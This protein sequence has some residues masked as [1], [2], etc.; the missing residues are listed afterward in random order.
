M[1][2]FVF[3]VACTRLSNTSMVVNFVKALKVLFFHDYMKIF[4]RN[5]RAV[6]I[7]LDG[8]PLGMIKTQNDEF[9]VVSVVY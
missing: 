1:T 8:L 6:V 9:L 7:C 4:S 2:F 5:L 3:L